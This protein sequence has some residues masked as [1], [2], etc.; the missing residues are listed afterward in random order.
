MRWPAT[1]QVT[2]EFIRN[3][4][5]VVREY[6]LRYRDKVKGWWTELGVDVCIKLNPTLLGKA[7]VDRLLHDVMGYREIGTTQ[8]AFDKDLQLICWNRQF[9]DILDLPPS[10]IRAGVE[11]AEILR[12]NARR[13]EVAAERIDEFVERLAAET[14]ARKPD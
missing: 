12:F 13:G 14:A 6:G 7:E 1:G 5:D 8:E 11:L 4:S 3:W 9:G 10:L 2:D